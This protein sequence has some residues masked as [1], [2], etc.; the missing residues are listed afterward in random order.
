MK[1]TCVRVNFTLPEGIY[2]AFR[3]IIPKRQ[4]SKVVSQLLKKEIERREKSI[5]EIARAV[6]NDKALSK[7]RALWDK[8]LGDGL[9]NLPWK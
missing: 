2:D 7:E 8:T 4:R 1:A 6:E 9:D 3:V 5:S